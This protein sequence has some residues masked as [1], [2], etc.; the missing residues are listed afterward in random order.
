VIRPDQAHDVIDAVGKIRQFRALARSAIENRRP[1]RRADDAAAGGKLGDDLV[2]LVAWGRTERDGIGVRAQH[3]CLRAADGI[4][5]RLRPAVRQVDH[6]TE[7]VHLRH[8]V[9]SVAAQTAVTIEAACANVALPVVRD[10]DDADADL[11]E[12]AQ[13]VEVAA[14]GLGVLHADDDAD[15]A[16][17]FG[18]PDVGGAG[19]KLQLAAVAVYRFAH[20]H[21]IAQALLDRGADAH[22]RQVDGGEARR[23][24]PLDHALRQDAPH[25][26][27]DEDARGSLR[28][29]SGIRSCLASHRCAVSSGLWFFPSARQR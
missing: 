28:L 6:E 24:Q 9:P 8:E 1:G 14:D 13:H 16:G 29:P 12:D 2:A 23:H 10:L 3:W 4:E 27:V 11:L 18:P 7:A 5:R 22:R 17:G 19:D 25:Q 26:A 15:A 21:D 20:A